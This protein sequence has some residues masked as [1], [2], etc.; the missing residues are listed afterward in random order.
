MIIGIIGC[1]AIA[2]TIVNY[3]L[4]N[5]NNIEIKYLFDRDINAVENLASKVD[6]IGISDIDD[7]GSDVELI[8]ECASP[9]AVKEFLP[10]LV[11]KGKNVILMSVGALMD[12]E[13]RDSIEKLAEENNSKIYIPS[14]AIAGIDS[15]NSVALGKIN[16]VYLETTKNPKSL[17]VENTEREVIFEGKASEAVLKFPFNI[18]VSATASLASKMDIDVKIISDPS[19]KRNTHKLVA[20]GEFGKLT[21]IS[22][23]ESL[24]INPKTSV[25]AAYSAVQLL[26]NLSKVIVIGN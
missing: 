22:E 2:N 11:K 20:E 12:E 15:L 5:P 6:G 9:T 14:G 8:L 13:F 25:L 16:S 4:E 18:N 19:F 7:F 3:L 1:G 21:T 10:D 17:G 23:N 24:K 26:I